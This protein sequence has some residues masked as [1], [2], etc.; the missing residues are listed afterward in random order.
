MNVSTFI[1]MNYE[2]R[3]MNYEIKN[4]PKTNPIKPN[5]K[6]CVLFLREI[7]SVCMS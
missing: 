3:T 2:Q 4:K 1:T 5:F 7:A 6:Q